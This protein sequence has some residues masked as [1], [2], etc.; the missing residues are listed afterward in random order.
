MFRVKKSENPNSVIVDA[1]S[2]RNTFDV[3]PGLGGIQPLVSG[4][5]KYSTIEVI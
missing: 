1:T 4:V 3:A 2:S 5:D